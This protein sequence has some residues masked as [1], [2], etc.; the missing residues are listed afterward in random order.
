MPGGKRHGASGAADD[1]VVPHAHEPHALR[2]VR[3]FATHQN[4]QTFLVGLA[5]SIGAGI[6]MGFAEALFGR[7]LADRDP[8]ALAARID[9]RPHDHARGLGHTCLFWFRFLANAFWIGGPRL[10]GIVVFFELWAI[11]YIRARY[12][13]TPFL[14]AVF[15]I[16]LGA[17]RACGPALSLSGLEGFRD[18]GARYPAALTPKLSALA[19]AVLSIALGQAG[20]SRRP[21]IQVYKRRYTPPSVNHDPAAPQ[22]IPRSAQDP[23]FPAASSPTMPSTARRNSLWRPR[24]VEVGPLS[25][26]R[27]QDQQFLS[28]PQAAN[29]V[30]APK[31][32]QAR[33]FYASIWNSATRPEILADKVYLG[34]CADHRA[35]VTR[36]TNSS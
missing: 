14:Q 17:H 19:G 20:A 9:L 25:A 26:L 28:M 16:V 33:L 13:D 29:P 21:K 34:G 7:R 36:N 4:W 24:L 31:C 3:A 15:Q 12:M 2:V 35:C 27:I 18:A 23:S 1:A 22:F 30:V 6:S 8:L 32:R 11:A 5:A 10:Q